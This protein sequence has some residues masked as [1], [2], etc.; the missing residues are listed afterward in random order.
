MC[1]DLYIQHKESWFKFTDVKADGN[2]MYYCLAKCPMTPLSSA[3]AIRKVLA[4]I[5]RKPSETLMNFFVEYHKTDDDPEP[6]LQ[7]WEDTVLQETEWG[8]NFESSLFGAIFGV[9]IRIVTNTPSG[10][11]ECDTRT[12]LTMY[13]IDAEK[14]I[15]EDSPAFYLYL[16]KHLQP[17]QP[18]KKPNHFAV[19]ELVDHD[20][21]D[22]SKL[23]KH[24]GA[25]DHS[26]EASATHQESTTQQGEKR[27]PISSKSEKKSSLPPKPEKKSS[28]PPLKHLDERKVPQKHFTRQIDVEKQ[29]SNQIPSKQ[30]GDGYVKSSQSSP[31]R[32][33]MSEIQPKQSSRKIINERHNSNNTAPRIPPDE[34]IQS[35]PS[36]QE[37]S[38]TRE[39]QQKHQLRKVG[40]DKSN[41]SN[42]SAEVVE[43]YGISPQSSQT[44]PKRQDTREPPRQINVEKAFPSKN[45]SNPPGEDYT[46]SSAPTQS[47]HEEREAQHKIVTRKSN[48]EKRN[49]VNTSSKITSDDHNRSPHTSQISSNLERKNT[50]QQ[51][52]E[53]VRKNSRGQRANKSDRENLG[54]AA[55][56]P[57]G[58]EN[59]VYEQ[60]K[61][62]KG[63]Q[64]NE[65]DGY[66]SGNLDK[67]RPTAL[68]SNAQESKRVIDQDNFQEGLDVNI[69]DGQ[70]AE[71]YLEMKKIV[72]NHRDGKR[73]GDQKINRYNEVERMNE[74][75]RAIPSDKYNE[76]K[77]GGNQQLGPSLDSKRKI[78]HSSRR[79]EEQSLEFA[80]ESRRGRRTIDMREEDVLQAGN[81]TNKVR[82]REEDRDALKHSKGHPNGRATTSNNGRR[83][84]DQ[85][86]ST[87]IPR[88]KEDA[89]SREEIPN[90][91]IQ[92]SSRDGE[93][94]IAQDKEGLD[95]Q[96]REV[97]DENYQSAGRNP[98]N[99][100]G[101]REDQNHPDRQIKLREEECK[102]RN[103]KF[104]AVLDSQKFK[105]LLE[106]Q[107][108]DRSVSEA[109][110]RPHR[111]ELPGVESIKSNS[112]YKDQEWRRRNEADKMEHGE[113]REHTQLR[114]S[115]EGDSH[116]RREQGH[117]RRREEETKDDRKKNYNHRDQG[118]RR[119]EELD[120][121]GRQRE[122]E[123]EDS[124]QKNYNHRDQA[125]EMD[126]IESGENREHTQRRRSFEGDTHYRREQG[127]GRRREE[128]T[129]DDRKKNYN[130]RDQGR[131]RVEELDEDGT[132]AREPRRRSIENDKSLTD[133]GRRQR[134][135][136][137]A[138]EESGH[139]E[140]ERRIRGESNRHDDGYQDHGRRR[141]N[142]SNGYDEDHRRRRNEYDEHPEESRKELSSSRRN[143]ISEQ[144]ERYQDHQSR[145]R[146]NG[147]GGYSYEEEYR[148]RKNE[149][150]EH[151]DEGR[152]ELSS[153]RRNEG[154]KQDES[155][156]DD[157]RRRRNDKSGPDEDRRHRRNDYEQYPDEGRKEVSS[158]RRTEVSEQDERYQDQSRRRKND[159]GGNLYEEEYRRRRNDYE[160]YPDDGR[161][162][163]SSRRRNEGKMQDES[164][165]DDSRR[166]RN[167]NDGHDEGHRRRRNDYEEY[168]E[169]GRKEMPSRR[170]NEVSQQDEGYQDHGRRRRNDEGG[171]SYE[172]EYRRRRNEHGEY[173]DEGRREVSRRREGVGAQEYDDY[174]EQ[175]GRRR[176]KATLHS[177][178]PARRGPLTQ[179]DRYFEDNYIHEDHNDRRF[180]TR[181]REVE[182]RKNEGRR[183]SV[184]IPMHQSQQ[185][186]EKMGVYASSHTSKS[187]FQIDSNGEA[188]QDRLHSPST[189]QGQN[190][191][192]PPR[193][194]ESH[195]PKAPH[196]SRIRSS[197]P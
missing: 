169:Q 93:S 14:V 1:D 191:P 86:N 116:Y 174:R 128:E 127:H 43:E 29:I 20:P 141:K 94:I 177:N 25:T 187:M 40:S 84:D 149:Y 98:K 60:I 13:E 113:N 72:D 145:R 121:D 5:M 87:R 56:D 70:T 104:K 37:R 90:R 18:T 139:H 10:L 11:E 80:K 32:L 184:Q 161:R 124:I 148:R 107:A 30:R 180:E 46:K 143:E 168:Q 99:I 182:D 81:Y 172:E 181:R 159:E 54:E 176:A 120:E 164:N 135:T 78:S 147:E 111:D 133:S 21:P 136:C 16:H 26:V 27:V 23:Y 52:G 68:A 153:R 71:K 130:H 92:T 158:R 97:Y 77:R 160:E 58:A 190:R 47:R 57:Q 138:P 53:G 19:L 79:H 118:R 62:Q 3:D 171:N 188:Y 82:G 126:K 4:E 157:G 137:V 193:L 156:Q 42:M 131:R 110:G 146:R 41:R 73:V 151:P 167:D 88:G 117:G 2:C 83:R 102:S 194:E 162:E 142:D 179:N 59:M 115:F 63:Q 154:N 61:I 119:V 134:S 38:K 22:G 165:Q 31:T 140:L 55:L 48:S 129:K 8:S 7:E 152:R 192:V 108:R 175:S 170:R 173:L 45:S 9:D 123:I 17:E 183:L 69:R 36:S 155:Y 196:G 197:R 33:E 12:L 101:A 44:T 89:R 163:V 24:P 100:L 6:S 114:R 195:V 105:A 132:R 15:P 91:R 178:S 66:G 185:R 35:P 109:R 75:F 28:L 166:R 125:H 150:E 96:P 34:N 76:P 39:I 189:R 65:F 51:R 122:E 95:S 49:F 106:G 144:D 50:P 112:G 85:L 64:N 74:Y 67:V 103:G 186:S